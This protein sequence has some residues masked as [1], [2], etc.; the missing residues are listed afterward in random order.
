MLDELSS[1]VPKRLWLR[2]MDEKGGS[3]SFEGTAASIDDVSV[4]LAGLKKSSYFT[5]PE[6]KKTTA[7]ADKKLKLVDF[8]ITAGVNYTPGVQVAAAAPRAP[9]KR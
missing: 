2:R 3:V 8:T 7:K 6:L 9:E 5:Y 4:F 1:L